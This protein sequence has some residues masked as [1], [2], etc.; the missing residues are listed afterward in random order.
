MALWAAAGLS[1]ITA[2]T[3]VDVGCDRLR[4]RVDLT[5]KDGR[6]GLYAMDGSRDIVDMAAC[7]M[8]DPAL[9]AW[10]CALRA[11]LP[12]VAK[13]GIRLRVNADGERGMWLDLANID[14]RDL[15]EEREWLARQHQRA[16]VEVG[17]RRRQ[18]AVTDER[19]RLMKDAPLSSWMRTTVGASEQPLYSAVGGFSQP[20]QQT[21]NGLVAAVMQQVEAIGA[22]RWLELFAGAGNLTLPIAARGGVV[23]AW[24]MEPS[25]VRGLQRSAQEAGL[26]ENIQARVMNVYRVSSVLLD[27]FHHARSDAILVDPPRSG[28][29]RFVEA[30]QAVPSLPTDLLYVSCYTETLV[31]DAVSLHALGYTAINPVGVDQFPHT[32]HAEWVVRFSLR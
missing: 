28:M 19:I 31:R 17:Q 21:N 11:D 32:P 23:H 26:S 24:E 8:L 14:I 7:P 15:L 22:S 5:L 25:A 3:W 13:A 10:L 16:H 9:E 6:L 2:P 1:P 30:L 27:A 12:P 4:Q 29:G 18:I 20:G